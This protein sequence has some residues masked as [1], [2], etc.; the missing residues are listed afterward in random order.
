LGLGLA[1]LG[2]LHFKRHKFF[3]GY[4]AFAF[5]FSGVFFVTY[6]N[7]PIQDP[8]ILGVLHRFYI[9]PAVLFSLW[10]G[11][12]LD[13]LLHW[14]E[15]KKISRV[16]CTALPVVL[17][18]GLFAWQFTT[19]VEEADFRDNHIA[20]DFARNLLLS[21]P[22]NSVFFVRGDVASIGVDY[23]QMVL[24]ER[25]DVICLDQ[26]K[27][28]YDWYYQQAKE[29][30]PHLVLPGERYDG[31]R[32]LNRHLIA[33][34]IDN[35]SICFMDFKEESYQHTFRAA[36]CGLVYKMLPKTQNFSPQE[37]ETSFDL[38]YAKMQK[39]G[40]E[41][42]YPATSFEYE[43]KQIY[44]E[45][46]FR[47]GFEFERAGELIKAEQYYKKALEM[48]P[49]NYKVLKNLAVLYFYKLHRPLDAIKIFA[50]YLA[51]NPG[52]AEAGKIKQIIAS[53]GQ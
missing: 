47:L 40:L 50:R 37:L 32:T 5:F 22:E 9:M 29:R 17:I 21:L 52:D 53:Y 20:E 49:V 4:L 43:V 33:N 19:N 6:A 12:G 44:A 31:A 24:G 46:F 7:I 39:R 35:F 1:V 23:L 25:P 34:N 48:N 41:R 3:Q 14:M 38:F 15:K 11:L 36:P 45:P 8:L 51:L 10:V 26:A 42:D 28:T 2:M 18:L 13:L 16:V 30:F 27:L